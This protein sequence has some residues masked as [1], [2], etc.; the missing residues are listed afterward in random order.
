MSSRAI[1]HGRQAIWGDQD[2]G[3][4]GL[5]RS[6][7]VVRAFYNPAEVRDQHLVLT[8]AAKLA[9]EHRTRATASQLLH[10]PFADDHVVAGAART[11][12][13]RNTAC[14]VLIE[15]IDVWAAVA[16]GESRAPVLHTET[17]G[18]LVDRLATVWTRTHLLAAAD[19]PAAR[20]GARVALHQLGEL[21]AAY[22][23]LTIDLRAKRRRLP[24]YQTPTGPN[25]AV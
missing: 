16:F 20:V 5:P 3:Y 10:D 8:V 12:T 14:A 13:A 21:S 15:Q 4:P 1:Q 6:A 11:I 25:A 23:D 19:T 9:A 24:L 2:R 22:D 17:L 7:M 18:Q